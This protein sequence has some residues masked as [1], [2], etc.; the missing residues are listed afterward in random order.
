MDQRALGP[1]ISSLGQGI[2]TYQGRL[3]KAHSR[4]RLVI[5]DNT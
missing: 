2:L 3:K 4:E 1:L 5:A